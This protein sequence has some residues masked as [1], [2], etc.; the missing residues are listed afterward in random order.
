MVDRKKSLEIGDG[1][2]PTELQTFFTV[3]TNTYLPT[4]TFAYYTM[5][6]QI[7]KKYEFVQIYDRSSI[8][9]TKRYLTRS[10]VCIWYVGP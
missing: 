5:A 9:P 10:P 7:Q 4:T 8:R 3:H 2:T 1:A 6:K